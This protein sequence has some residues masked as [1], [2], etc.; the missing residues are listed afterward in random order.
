MPTYPI[1]GMYY[2]PPAQALVDSLPVGT[3]MILRADPHGEVSGSAHNDPTAIC[4]VMRTEA[5]AAETLANAEF[6]AALSRYGTSIDDFLAEPEWHI[7]FVPKE[8]AYEATNS[9][10]P[11]GVDIPGIFSVSANGKPR[12]RFELER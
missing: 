2:R 6:I 4:I 12:I 8:L 5:V 3:P 10:F 9:G 1:V 7:G 11:A